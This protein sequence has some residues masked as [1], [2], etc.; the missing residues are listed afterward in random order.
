MTERVTGQLNGGRITERR[1]T[2]Y[3]GGSMLTGVPIQGETVVDGVPALKNGAIGAYGSFGRVV[4]LMA[5]GTYQTTDGL[6][7]SWGLE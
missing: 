2:L 3:Y 5:D 1:G 7:G 6:K 4:Y